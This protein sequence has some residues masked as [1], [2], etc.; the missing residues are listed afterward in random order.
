MRSLAAA[1][2]SL[3]GLTALTVA[4]AFQDLGGLNL[5]L[6]LAIAGAKAC[7][8]ALSFMHLRNESPTVRLWAAAGILWLLIL[9]VLAMADFGTREVDVHRP[10]A[11]VDRR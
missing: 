11:S 10:P 7:L 4:A 3:L 6:A 8:V 1:Y 9:I 2:A 5:P